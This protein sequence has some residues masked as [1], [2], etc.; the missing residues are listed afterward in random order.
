MRKE[1]PPA[2]LQNVLPPNKDHIY[3]EDAINNPF[4]PRSNTFSLVNAW[5]LAESALLSYAE[6]DFAVPTFQNAGLTVWN[7]YVIQGSSTQCY[8]VYT[9][10]FVVVA[11]RGTQVLK[12]SVD[13][14]T[15]ESLM[16]AL[17]EV[18]KDVVVD[19]KVKLVDSGQGG[20]VHQGFMDALNEVWE[21]QLLPCLN[22]L[23]SEEG[24][25]RVLWMT[26]HSLGA[27]LAT[28]AA[29]RFGHVQ[30]VYT[31]G[32]PRVGDQSFADDYYVNTY[33]FVNNNDIVPRLPWRPYVHVGQL[34]YIDS[35][36][37]LIDNVSLWQSISEQ[38]VGRWKHL[39]N[40]IGGLRNGWNFQI[41]ADEFNDHAPLFY[42]LH[43]WNLLGV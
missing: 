6:P 5:W 15:N 23:L 31:F 33:R 30:G 37:N 2:T 38:F 32:S 14:E 36:G 41:P 9:D 42:A 27:A 1:I 16:T 7:N 24:K 29:D 19:S 39:I 20:N 26:G 34:K 12:P 21:D 40:S 3:F 43:I 13:Q 10:D 22:K 28:L 25:N 17:R 4:Q 35:D 18:L 11:F 8:V